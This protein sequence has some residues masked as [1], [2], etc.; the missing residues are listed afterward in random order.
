M[1]GLMSMNSYVPGT[2]DWHF[3]HLSSSLYPDG[4]GYETAHL[5]PSVDATY[6]KMYCPLNNIDVM[7]NDDPEIVRNGCWH[8][9]GPRV[10]S[11]NSTDNDFV[12]GTNTFCSGYGTDF[13]EHTNALCLP[14]E[15]CER[16]CTKHEDCQSIDMHRVLPQCYLNTFTCADPSLWQ[17]SAEWDI[18]SKI[19]TP[20]EATDITND[21]LRD[22][23]LTMTGFGDAPDKTP[24]NPHDP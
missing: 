14:R 9:C 16:L 19:V 13:T 2:N 4:I 1:Q 8:K 5:D 23:Y 3:S 24:W 22:T 20:T 11:F 17:Y 15:E 7:Y 12:D 18:L 21:A 10:G 6:G